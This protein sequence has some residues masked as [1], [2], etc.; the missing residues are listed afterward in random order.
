MTGTSPPS[1]KN[2]GAGV[3]AY[4]TDW[5]N[6][7]PSIGVNWTPTPEAGWLY[8]YFSIMKPY[9]P[10]EE[11]LMREWGHVRRG[12][13][14]PELVALFRRRPERRSTFINALTA[15]SHDVAFS[16]LGARHRKLLYALAAPVT[17]LGYLLHRPST[18]GTETAF[19]W[20]K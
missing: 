6:L 18:R 19:A 5:N 14:D 13:R 11:E 9:C 10:H 17:A 1:Y 4:D 2:L 12:Y 16:R 20:R 15:F 3:K 8:P 7:A